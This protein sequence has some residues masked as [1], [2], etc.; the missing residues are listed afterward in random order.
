LDKIDFPT[1]EKTWGKVIFLD[2]DIQIEEIADAIASLK[3]G[4]ALGPDL[5]FIKH[6]VA[7]YRVK[8]QKYSQPSIKQLFNKFLRE[9]RIM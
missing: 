5:I 3:T 6:F 2:E 9:I 1:A 8:I 4:K 7:F